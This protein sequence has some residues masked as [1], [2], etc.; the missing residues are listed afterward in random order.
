MPLGDFFLAIFIPEDKI[1]EIKNAADVVDVISESVL[2]KQSGKNF[3]GLC[4]FHS[5]KTPSFTVNP[6]KQIFYC[7]G[8]GAGGNVFSFLMKYGGLSFPEAVKTLAG[9]YGITI[10]ARKLSPEQRRRLDEREILLDINRRTMEFFRHCLTKTPSGEK[11][12]IYLKKRGMTGEIL[13]D[14]CLGY[15]P[16][17]WDNLLTFLSRKGIALKLVEKAGLIVARKEKTGFYDR[18]RDR[19]IFPIFNADRQ[20]VGFGG[21]VMDDAL[22]KYLNSP[23]TL[24]YNKRRSLFG[25]HLA[26]DRCRQ[27]RTVFIVEG[28]FDL[29]ALHQHGMKNSVATLG[30]AVTAEHVRLLKGYAERAILVFDSDDAGLKAAQRS[31]S[32]FMDEGV[33]ARILVLPAGYDPDAYLLEFGAGSFL[34]AAGSAR[35]I[36][37]FLMDCAEKKHGLSTRGKIRIVSDLKEPLAA[38]SD[39]VARS[40]YV[41]EIGE[42][43]GIDEGA[44]LGSLKKVT[45]GIRKMN[46]PD[47]DLE[48][49][50]RLERRMITM[51]LQFPSI[52]SEMRDRNMIDLFE[53]ETLR[54]IGRFILSCYND[55]G[56]QVSDM[57]TQV[58]TGRTTQEMSPGTPP[59][60]AMIDEEKKRLL[61]ELSIGEDIWDREGCLRLMTQFESRRKKAEKD[62]LRKIKAAEASNDQQLLLSLLREKQLQAIKKA[63]NN[64][65]LSGG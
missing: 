20:V 2:L 35:G 65:E 41:K 21:R 50:D 36:M 5:E 53:D 4:P 52:L 64:L 38:V 7:F 54:S 29:M 47:S 44:I 58:M 62:L 15:S 1:S 57:M 37:G 42:R 16:A 34:N 24:V 23:E 3:L 33:D 55:T 25:L 61:A 30:T 19:I 43:L 8:C 28:Y 49:G 46:P 17:G 6:E 27:E 12:R 31:I 39:S 40:L 22:P 32:I 59:E 13:S 56:G 9:K 14:F 60:I 51:M 10:P 18:F 26:R 45:L 63:E 48:T 11:A